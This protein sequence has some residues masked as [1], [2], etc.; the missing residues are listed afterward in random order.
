MYGGSMDMELLKG[1]VNRVVAMA[2]GG[3]LVINS[4]DHDT[5]NVEYCPV[6]T[7]DK[8]SKKK[9]LLRI[10]VRMKG[11]KKFVDLDKSDIA[12]TGLTL[13]ELLEYLDKSDAQKVKY[14]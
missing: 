12:S 6:W 9:R 1:I 13:Y 7:L 10:K 8:N 14:P 2:L 5:K 4:I 11:Q 3:M